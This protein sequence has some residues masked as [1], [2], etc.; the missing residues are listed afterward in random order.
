[1][2]DVTRRVAE[3]KTVP[4]EKIPDVAVKVAERPVKKVL[5]ELSSN[6]A[7]GDSLA[8][9]A[10]KAIAAGEA[11]EK[12]KEE[13]PEISHEAARMGREIGPDVHDAI[14]RR[15][16]R[17]ESDEKISGGLAGQVGKAVFEGGVDPEIVA[18]VSAKIIA[19]Q[20]GRV[21]AEQ[22]AK[23]GVKPQTARVIL[24]ERQAKAV[25]QQRGRE[26]QQQGVVV[27]QLA[28]QIFQ[29]SAPMTGVQFTPEQARTA[30]Q[31][32]VT[33]TN[34]GANA[35]EATIGAMQNVLNAMQQL[36][37]R[38]DGLEMQANMAGARAQQVGHQQAKHRWQKP[39]PW[40]TIPGG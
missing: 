30:A 10:R 28:G 9:T 7:I 22:V 21:R 23:G 6:A 25:G 33:M 31:Q 15:A 2:A 8:A 19:E 16:A 37:Q 40:N 18:D 12:A 32:A 29:E 4:E 26:R 17:K 24:G 13:K 3:S 39:A 14:L 1:M 36:G 20:L 35:T 27:E 11:K 34:R 38:L 5:D